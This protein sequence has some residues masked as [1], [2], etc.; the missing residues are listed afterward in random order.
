VAENRM[1]R[2]DDEAPGGA[3]QTQ[4]QEGSENESGPAGNGAAQGAARQAGE[5]P[6]G[7]DPET[8]RRAEELVDRMGERVGHCISFLGRGVLKLAARA[9]EEAEDIW[10]EAQQIRR[11]GQS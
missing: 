7:I 8:M 9:R 3:T 11:G 10:A 2:G 1:R 5:G 4:P 6:G